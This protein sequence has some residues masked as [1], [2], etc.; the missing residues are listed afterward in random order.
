[1]AKKKSADLF[2]DAPATASG[3]KTP[4]KQKKAPATSHHMGLFSMKT[5]CSFYLKGLVLSRLYGT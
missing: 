2:D 3:A 4:A 1:M 5:R